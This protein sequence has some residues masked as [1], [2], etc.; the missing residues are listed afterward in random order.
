MLI[1][2]LFTKMI[3][4]KK[5]AK[6][7]LGYL[8]ERNEAVTF[9]EILDKVL[10]SKDDYC[11]KRSN[12]S[13]LTRVLREMVQKRLIVHPERGV[14]LIPGAKNKGYLSFNGITGRY[15]GMTVKAAIVEYLGKAQ[16]E[17]TYQEIGKGLYGESYSK[18]KNS[19]LGKA[20]RELLLHDKAIS[21]PG[22]GIYKI[23]R[24]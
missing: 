3:G 5:L 22:W 2:F 6:S 10:P 11:I 8:T 19:T 24:S 7:V 16:K 12:T 1:C 15:K 21:N 18:Q 14:Y 23:N 4:S 9:S 17:C 13:F 20:L